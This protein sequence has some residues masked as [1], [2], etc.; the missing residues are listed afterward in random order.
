MNKLYYED[1]VENINYETINQEWQI[2]NIV[3]FSNDIKELFPYQVNALKNVIKLLNFYYNHNQSKECLIDQCCALG[4]E[5]S[6][7]NINQFEKRKK[8]ELFNILSQYY[9]IKEDNNDKKY[10]DAQNIF[11]RA[12]FWMATA[13]GKTIVLIK[14]IEVLDKLQRAKLIP[15]NE[16]MVLFPDAS[17]E[18]QFKKAVNKYNSGKN[19]QIRTHSLKDYDEVKNRLTLFDEINVYSYRSDLLSDEEKAKK[20]NINSYDN[21]GNWFIFLDE[22]HKGD[23]SGDS[24]RQ[25]YITQWSRNGFLFNFSATFTDAVDYATTVF[26]YNLEKFIEDGYGKNIFVSNSY[27]TFKKKKDELNDLLKQ[28]QVLK[29]L[30]TSTLIKKHKQNGYYHNPLIVTLVDTV[31][32]EDSDLY[33]FFKEIEKIATG[34][35]EENSFEQAK[36]EL[37]EELYPGTHYALGK[38]KITKQYREEILNLSIKDILIN[39][40]NA[41]THGKI[42]IKIGETS[43][44]IAMQLQTSDSPFLLIKIGDANKF[45]RDKL[46]DNYVV[47]KNYSKINYF[48]SLN[49]ST[50]KINILL[51]SRAFYEGWDSNRPNVMNFINIGS[52]DAKK[53]VLQSIGRGVRIQPEENN[54]NK[55]KRANNND[56]FKNELF[57]TLFVYATNKLAVKSILETLDE[58]KNTDE[59]LIE[60]IKQ[61]ETIFDLIL[62]EYKTDESQRSRAKFFIS[63][64]CLKS[65]E[66]YFK[67]YDKSLF[68]LLFKQTNEDYEF[69]KQ[70]FVDKSIYS[71]SDKHNFKNIKET[72]KRI[73]DHIHR[74]Q[75]IVDKIRL[76][77]ESDII[78]FKHIKALL[79]QEECVKIQNLINK[80][81]QSSKNIIVRAKEDLAQG[82]IDIDEFTKIIATNASIAEKLSYNGEIEFLNL[83]EH[84]YTPII[85]STN[86]RVNYLKH[87]INVESE[88]KFVNN[89]N[90]FIKNNK[91]NKNWMFS[92]IDQTL[93]NV[94]IWYF[95][96]KNNKY[97]K[98]YPDFI[99]WIK[100]DNNYHVFFV[101]PKGFQNTDYQFKI[102]GYQSLFEE[103]GESKHFYF[104]F[105]NKTYDVKFSL[106]MVGDATV[107]DP[108][109][110]YCIKQ[111]EF[112]WLKGTD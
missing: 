41:K 112:T 49:N 92:K 35:I 56:S 44:E 27:F 101:D 34:D 111:N 20:I 64:V 106:L 103:N 88:I 17:I 23:K 65:V 18:N 71:I 21:N 66:Q 43:K 63:D 36:Q 22:A 86:D 12:C 96:E 91:I 108:Y 93:D 46:S 78:H 54:I 51:G 83:A 61:N 57:E 38:D 4:L 62:P 60:S 25:N 99:F 26:N 15:N 81:Q 110:K 94:Y 107:P 104:K 32:E 100:E 2:E 67:A 16:F 75:K 42:E 74:K 55:R 13:S 45:R 1:F 70:S 11:N 72:L 73:L 52:G 79:N 8:N 6:D 97:D 82:K 87:I 69:L 102:H 77:N 10:I 47:G 68:M 28:K 5:K 14:L 30:I 7:Y 84:Y 9:E 50:C 19:R 90:N 37:A 85:V 80:A 98:F 109:K 89:L 39:V 59:L 24:K 29:S 76:V 31:N 58:Q 3:E 95:N 33:M 53:F 40:Y 105:N 48:N